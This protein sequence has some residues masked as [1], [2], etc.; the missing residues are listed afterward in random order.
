[1]PFVAIGR[2]TVRSPCP[3]F[4]AGLRARLRS[5]ERVDGMVE[6]RWGFEKRIS[7]NVDEIR[8]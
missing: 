6:G 4:V 3:T 8:K 5:W 7:H 1:M 2:G